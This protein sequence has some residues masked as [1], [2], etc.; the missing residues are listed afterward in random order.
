[1]F[2]K[3]RTSNKD[4]FEYFS[5]CR[6]ENF[7]LEFELLG[8]VIA[9]YKGRAAQIIDISAGGIS[10]ECGACQEGE[11]GDLQIELHGKPV[12]NVSISVKIHII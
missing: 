6:R 7:R 10:F 3:K 11:T 9:N 1:M 4:L 5:S 2:W 12:E 8:P